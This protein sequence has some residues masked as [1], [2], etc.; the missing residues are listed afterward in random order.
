ME[1]IHFQRNQLY[2]QIW[3]TSTI[4]LAKQYGISPFQLNRVCKVL[5]IPTPKVGHWAKIYAGKK[6]K[7]PPLKP[8][9]KTSY[10]LET[11]TSTNV[12]KPKKDTREE[13]II[14]VRKQLRGLHPLVLS[15]YQHI[16]Q[17]ENERYHYHCGRIKPFGGNYLDVNVSPSGLRR[18]MLIMDAIIKEGL[19]RGYGPKAERYDYKGVRSYFEIQEEK[20]YFRIFEY[21]NIIKRK[22]D[23]QSS[24]RQFEYEYVPNGIF[25]LSL[26]HNAYFYDEKTITDSKSR[27]VESKLGRFFNIVEDLVHLSIQER[28][29]YEIKRIR[30]Q[31]EAV[32]RE[33]AWLLREAEEKRLKSLEEH[34]VAY[35][36]SQFIY[37]FIDEVERQKNQLSLDAYEKV[38]FDEWLFWARKHADSLNPLKQTLNQILESISEKK[39]QCQLEL[40][41]SKKLGP[42]SPDITEP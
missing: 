18:A 6:V 1:K 15:T 22:A 17:K 35:T 24:Y 7:R 29:E 30:E 19:R 8:F 34:S 41:N 12:S 13:K 32:L 25:K 42:S 9:D 23:S 31:E 40:L 37:Q 16:K 14:P 10:V 27:L 3:S 5:N 20:I 21:S 39:N 33:K 4:R 36:K 2:E 28:K 38:H 26:C 11:Y